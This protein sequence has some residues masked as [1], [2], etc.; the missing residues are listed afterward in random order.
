MRERNSQFIKMSGSALTID[1]ISHLPKG[2]TDNH[3]QSQKCES[4]N[5]ARGFFGLVRIIKSMRKA[6]RAI[7]PTSYLGVLLMSCIQHF[8]N[9]SC[10]PSIK[11]EGLEVLISRYS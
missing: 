10:I 7:F 9:A 8:G 1:E 3:G 5:S 4:A 2:D 6:V 11:R